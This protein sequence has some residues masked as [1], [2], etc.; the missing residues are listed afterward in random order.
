M[1]SICC[2]VCRVYSWSGGGC[3]AV[4]LHLDRSHNCL[5]L[6]QTTSKVS[7]LTVRLWVD[8]TK[9]LLSDGHVL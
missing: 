3:G 2:T 4:G 8:E 5:R 7:R 6:L 1:A 9:F